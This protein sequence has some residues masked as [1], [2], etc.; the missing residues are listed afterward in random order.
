MKK[1]EF[2]EKLLIEKDNNQ[3]YAIKKAKKFQKE[4]ED[5]E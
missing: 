1:A 5:N 2:L 4:K 3:Y